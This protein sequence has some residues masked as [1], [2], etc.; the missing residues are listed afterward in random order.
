[1]EEVKNQIHDI[2]LKQKKFFTTGE[3]KKVIFRIENLKKLKKEILKNEL[4]IKEALKK[5]LNKSYSESYMTEIGITLSELNYVI[6]H[7]KKWSRKKIVPTPIVHFPSIS[8]TVSEPYGIVLILS[9]WN[10]PFM[11]MMEPLIGAISSGNTIILKP[12]E[13]APHTANIIEKII[14]NC[15]DE[16]YVAVIQGEKEVSQNLINSKVDY[17]F[18]TGGTK[19]GKIVMEAASKNLIPVTLE[20]GGKSPC[21]IDKNCNIKLATKRLVFGKLLNAGQTCIAPDYVLINKK[22]KE[23]L[24][25][26]IKYYLKQFLGESVLN[27]K[28]YPKI[29][30]KRHYDRL[31]ALIENQKILLGGKS[32]IQTLKL[33]PTLIDKPSRE[34]MIMNEEIFGPILPIIEYEDVQEAIDYIHSY[35]KPLAL[36]LFTNDKKIENKI[37]SQI[38]FG[39]GCINDTIIHI[40]NPNMPFGGVGYSGIG[41]YHGKSSFNTFSHNRSITKKFRLDLPLR[42]M[43]Y[44][45]WKDKIVK[46]FMK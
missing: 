24:I 11:L 14:K 15:F 33:E 23:E 45:D 16:E 12:S 19:V 5:D 46:I 22:V 31:K 3:T 10:Y 38:S 18:Y 13:F 26:W 29:I 28:D 6:K 37:L 40:A 36:Y 32:N 41:D 1:M 2:I 43:P 17:I 20:L 30:N 34:S 21:I 27:N 9:P 4:N 7:T 8:Y 39:G 42:Y 25:K 35:E 44:T